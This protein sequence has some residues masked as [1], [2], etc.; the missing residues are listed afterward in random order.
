MNDLGIA[1]P[2]CGCTGRKDGRQCYKC[3]GK[4]FLEDSTRIPQDPDQPG[5]GFLAGATHQ[6]FPMG[7]VPQHP[8]GG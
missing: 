3:G 7:G 6:P 5:S 2:A 1:C 4:G 8:E